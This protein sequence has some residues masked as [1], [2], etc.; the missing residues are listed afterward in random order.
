MQRVWDIT[1]S[2]QVSMKVRRRKDCGMSQT[3]T[4]YT[5]NGKVERLTPNVDQKKVFCSLQKLAVISTAWN[6]TDKD[7]QN[8]KI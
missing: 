1:E 3:D 8:I 6:G 4:L 2:E 5:T 7:P